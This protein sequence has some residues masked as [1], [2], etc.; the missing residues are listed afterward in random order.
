MDEK[1]DLGKEDGKEAGKEEKKEHLASAALKNISVSTKHSVEL[2]RFL[3]YRS[4]LFTKKFLEEVIAMKKAVPFRW[5]HRDVGHKKGMAAGRY[6]VKAAKEFLRLVKSVE[7]NAHT[8]GLDTSSLK[9]TKL[10]A[11]KASIPLTGGRF[12]GK[13]KRTH[14]EIEVREGRRLKN[15]RKTR[16]RKQSE[17]GEKL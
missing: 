17:P 10:I 11:N 6:P 2:S 16:R 9:I 15:D 5:F 7:A 4:V 14:L 1:A 8:Q 12:R 3:R 13:T